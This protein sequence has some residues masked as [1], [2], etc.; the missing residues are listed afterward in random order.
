MVSERVERVLVVAKTHL[1]V[2]FTDLAAAVRRRYLHE[3]L[4]RA[5][6]TA[7]ELRARGGPERLV[8]TT[9]SWILT[10]ALDATDAPDPDEV[11]AAVARGDVAW[12][13]MPFTTHTELAD[14]S[15][16]EHGLSLSAALDHRF[17]RRTRAAKL[18]DVPGHTRGLVSVLAD[19]GVDL[20]HIGVNPAWPAPQVPALFRWVDPAAPD[21]PGGGSPAVTVLYQ[22]GAYGDV[23]L[24]PGTGVAVA[25]T[26]TGDNLGPPGPADVIRTWAGLRDRFPGA[27]LRAATLDDVADVVRSVAA[28]L[29]AVT[30]ELGDRWVHGGASD[31]PKL[32]ALRGLCR[33]R[34]TWLADGR[35]GTD[36]PALH[37]ASTALL[38]AAEHTWGLDQK[39]WWPETAHWSVEDLAAVIDRAD[40]QRFASSWAE[41]RAY[42]GRFVDELERGGR[43]DLAAEAR[44]VVDASLRPPSPAVPPPDAVTAGRPVRVGGWELV[45]DP[46]DGAL[47]AA[48]APGGARLAAPG[49]S[50]GRLRLRTH[51]A[52]EYDR[53]LAALPV[54]EE[55]RWWATWDNT[56][57]GLDGSGAVSREWAPEVF[58]VRA[59]R[60]TGPTGPGDVCVV[61]LR[62]PDAANPL[63]AVPDSL[64]LAYGVHDG[65]PGTLWCTVSWRRRPAARWPETVWWSFDPP[66]ADPAAWRMVK[67]GE[68]VDPADVVAGGA[69]ALHAV[70]S[71]VHPAVTVEPLDAPLVAPGRPDPLPDGTPADHDPSAGWHF[72]LVGNLWGTNFP[73][74]CP[75]DATFRIAITPG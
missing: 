52:A 27:D 50:L 44:R 22:A 64:Q 43:A 23:H 45:V 9:G 65:D 68:A 30:G 14:R 6:S 31:P 47:V 1:D 42:L 21:L 34:A 57:P 71:L 15:L 66:V 54:A 46:V 28:S 69:V 49:R 63:A 72:C 58:D 35:A 32:A 5:M 29:P 61:D 75:G 20:L 40:T 4:P 55:D 41:Q 13:A 17:D 18:T 70:E 19:R 33:L 39:T 60:V 74:W 3:F 25:V 11:A 73:M 37:Q 26:M 53:Y 51:D 8:W 62:W 10:E 59:G 67:L 38:L 12:H 7:A 56:K 48:G 24:L 36:E 16:L 2:G